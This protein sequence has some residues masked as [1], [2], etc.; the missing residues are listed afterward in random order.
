VGSKAPAGARLGFAAMDDRPTMTAHVMN[1]RAGEVLGDAGD[2]AADTMGHPRP[3]LRRDAWSLLDGTWEFA[4]DRDA[5]AE[6]PDEIVWDRTIRV[7]FAPET[8]K[9]TIGDTAYVK[10][11]WYRRAVSAPERVNAQRIILHFGAVDHSAKVWID[12]QLVA[13]HDGG[14]TP[15]AIDVTRQLDDGREHEL[16]VCA[17]DDPVDLAKPRGKQDWEENP[18]SI[19]YERTT[20]IWQSVWMEAVSA[21]RLECVHWDSD[22]ARLEVSSDVSIFGRVRDGMTLRIKLRVRTRQLVDDEVTLQ[23]GHSRVVRGFRLDATGLDHLRESLL[24]TPEHP[25]LV[26]ATLELRDVDGSLL[27]RVHSYTAI[28]SVGVGGGH[29]LLNGRP[30]SLRLVLDQGYWPDSGLTPPDDD[31]LRRDIELVKAMGFNGV[32]K[33]QKIED[34]RFL[35]WADRLGLMVWVEM[36]PAYQFDRS[37]IGRVTQEWI[38]VIERDRSHPCIV[39]WVPFNESSGLIDLPGRQDEQDWVRALTALT[40]ALD[41]SRPVISN[42]GW[43]TFGGD[44]IAVHDY[45]QQPEQLAARWSGDLRDAITGFGTHRRRQTLDEDAGEWIAGRPTRPIVLSEFGGI[46]W[47]PAAPVRHD[48]GATD[49]I[50][51]DRIGQPAAW[52]YSTVSSVEEFEQQFSQLVRAVHSIPGLAGFC[53]TQFADTF[54]EINGLVTRDRQPK[55]ALDAIA[56]AIRGSAKSFY[57]PFESH[58]R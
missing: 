55:I 49:D 9:S 6:H 20:G 42:D 5:A 53:Y 1:H 11:C 44:I 56:D 7:P 4:F 48:D 23:A 19:W 2:G 18:H 27:D 24:W 36:P 25:V 14:Y 35:H 10:A 40:S 31:A 39:A 37:A 34:P 58:T 12:G 51:Q 15:F 32:R 16:A 57:D 41:P 22:L 38:S 8:T 3:L 52:G 21:T 54:Q 29:F 46:G 30:Q 17:H 33:H 28:R 50:S 26:D 47:S 13:T 45:E 43:E